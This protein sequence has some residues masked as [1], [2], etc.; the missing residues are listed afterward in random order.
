MNEFILIPNKVTKVFISMPMNGLS[1][2]RI[3]KKCNDILIANSL[4]PQYC[5][6]V[7]LLPEDKVKQLSPL[8]CFIEGLNKLTE[9]DCVIIYGDNSARGVSLEQQICDMYKIPYTRTF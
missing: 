9:A 6:I 7:N 2:K 1:Y 4:S 8:E 5:E 3:V